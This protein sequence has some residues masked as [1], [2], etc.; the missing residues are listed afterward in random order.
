MY[1]Y[2]LDENEY[3][4]M[5]D[6]DNI[7][8]RGPAIG[9]AFEYTPNDPIK[10]TLFKYGSPEKVEA[11]AAQIRKKMADA[12]LTDINSDI[13]TIAGKIPVEELNKM[14]DISG[15]VGRWYET[16][17]HSKAAPA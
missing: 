7:L 6:R 13:V 17:W 11:W 3:V 4:L 9:I 14:I 15:Y 16:I 5:D 10:G 1:H 2:V 12:G 8:W